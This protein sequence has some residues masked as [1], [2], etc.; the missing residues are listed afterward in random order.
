[1]PNWCSNTVIITG[2]EQDIDRLA[3]EICLQ[4]S[5][6]NPPVLRLERLLPTPPELLE[7]QQTNPATAIQLLQRDPEEGE[8]DDWYSWRVRNWGT[9]WD[10]DAAVEVGPG[11]LTSS[12]DSAWSPPVAAMRLISER[13]PSLSVTIEYDEPGNDFSGVSTFVAG[14]TVEA[15]QGPSTWSEE[16]D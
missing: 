2:P 11:T 12:F 7:N 14:E 5:K 15:S 9:K 13:Y 1:V 6:N 10:I 8:Q 3:Q 16:D 4:E